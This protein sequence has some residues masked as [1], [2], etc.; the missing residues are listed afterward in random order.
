MKKEEKKVSFLEKL[1][2]HMDKDTSADEVAEYCKEG[3]EYYANNII[4]AI[5]PIDSDDLPYII[6][7]LDL[8]SEKLKQDIDADMIPF[9]EALK[10][11]FKL[12]FK[13]VRILIN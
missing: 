1:F 5:N 11:V 10:K 3:I 8:C 6:A 7:V 13:R 12:C 4:A 2:D 9:T